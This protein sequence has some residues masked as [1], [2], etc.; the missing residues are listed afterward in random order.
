[1][2]Q[3]QNDLLITPYH[4]VKINNEWKFPI[5]IGKLVNH[6]S[7]YLFN[8]V[9]DSGH[10]VMANKEACCTLGHNFKENTVIE[11]PYFGTEKIINDLR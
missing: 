5:E 1:M 10:I 11:H 6:Q 7:D 4:P 3:L 2:V 8:F 9:L